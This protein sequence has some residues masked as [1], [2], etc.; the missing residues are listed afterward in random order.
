VAVLDSLSV[1]T[2]V[3]RAVLVAVREENAPCSAWPGKYPGAWATAVRVAE[4]LGITSAQAN[5]Y[6]RELVETGS[7]VSASPWPGPTHGYQPAAELQREDAI[8]ALPRVVE[9]EREWMLNELRR[10]ASLHDGLAPRQR[11]WSKERDPE[12]GWPRWDKVA[13]LFEQEALDKGIRYWVD[14]R[15]KTDCPC[16]TGRHYRNDSGDVFCE[17]CFDCLG[18]CPHGTVGRWVGPSGWRYAL[19][20]AGL[21]S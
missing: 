2:A 8:F 15:C 20:V 11:D 21:V 5:S 3:S 10:W 16:S 13:E 4:I 14:E 18:R 1:H 6:L 17:G 9:N 7:V 12:R 19:Q